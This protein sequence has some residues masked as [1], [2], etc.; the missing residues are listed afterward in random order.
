MS[1]DPVL[2]NLKSQ[3]IGPLR[4]L[5]STHFLPANQLDAIR[6]IMPLIQDAEFTS[7][8]FDAQILLKCDVD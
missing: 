8:S 2:K 4:M 5:T 6:S 7:G 3:L 1:I